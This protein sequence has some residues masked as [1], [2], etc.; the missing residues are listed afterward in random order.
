MGYESIGHE[1]K[2]RMGYWLRGHEGKRNNCLS[3]IQQVGQNNIKTKRLSQLKLDT[4][5]LL[6]PKHYKYGSAF[7]Y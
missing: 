6:L 7:R 2:D 1:A 4:N 5:P 3:K